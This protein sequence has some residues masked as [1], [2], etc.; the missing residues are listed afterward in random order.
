MASVLVSALDKVWARV[1]VSG[2]ERARGK[3]SGQGGAAD[4]EEV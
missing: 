2:Q 3:V 1:Q 4:A